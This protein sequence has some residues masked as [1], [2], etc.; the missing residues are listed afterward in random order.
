MRV[1]I[2][3]K[4]Q[5]TLA[6]IRMLGKGGKRSHLGFGSSRLSCAS[7]E[8]SRMYIWNWGVLR[9]AVE[10]FASSGGQHPHEPRVG[11]ASNSALSAPPLP[12]PGADPGGQ[13]CGNVLPVLTPMAWFVCL[14]L[15]FSFASLTVPWTTLHIVRWLPGSR[16]MRGHSG[17][18]NAIPLT[19]VSHGGIWTQMFWSS[20]VKGA[21]S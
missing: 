4:V 11:A 18:M 21:E 1:L 10:W 17:I 9:I 14:I 20:S 3:I 6:L 15:S 5:K 8:G 7:H 2:R 12:L 19:R 13:Y 16:S